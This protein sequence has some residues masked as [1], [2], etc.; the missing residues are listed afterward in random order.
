MGHGSMF[1]P[2]AAVCLAV[3]PW[4][5]GPHPDHGS[6]GRTAPPSQP[7]APVQVDFVLKLGIFEGTCVPLSQAHRKYNFAPN[8]N[9]VK[10]LKCT[11]SQSHSL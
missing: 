6:S 8:M 9:S 10:E 1:I 11:Q 4:E 2:G 7:L 5:T 3:K